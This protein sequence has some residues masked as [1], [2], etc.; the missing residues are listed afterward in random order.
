MVAFELREGLEHQDCEVQCVGGAEEADL[1]AAM[2]REGHEVAVR[3]GLCR[4]VRAKERRSSKPSSR[5][6]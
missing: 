6:V 4:Y 2:R 1:L 5:P 3:S